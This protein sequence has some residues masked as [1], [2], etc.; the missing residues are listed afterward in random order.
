MWKVGHLEVET[1][2]CKHCGYPL[3]HRFKFTPRM[4]R[5]GSPLVWGL[6][7]GTAKFEGVVFPLMS[8][9]LGP[10]SRAGPEYRSTTRVVVV[11]RITLSDVV[12]IV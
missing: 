1:R 7:E 3:F 11:L 5:S 8:G 9:D 6:K 4:A 10:S 12:V 2:D